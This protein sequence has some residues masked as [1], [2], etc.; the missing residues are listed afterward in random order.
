MMAFTRLLIA[1][2]LCTALAQPPPA[3]RPDLSQWSGWGGSYLNDRH[4]QNS[5]LNSATL[6]SL[7]QHCRYNVTVGTSAP[8]AIQ[9]STAYFTTYGGLLVAYN[10]VDCKALWQTNVTDIIYQYGEPSPLQLAVISAVTRS[11]PQIGNGVLYIGTL[12]H[13]CC[14]HSTRRLERCLQRPRYTLIRTHNSP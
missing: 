7:K 12:I 5:E 9:G 2:L 3:Y 10:F 1:S 8:P 4:V 14:W 13:A 11:S 6:T